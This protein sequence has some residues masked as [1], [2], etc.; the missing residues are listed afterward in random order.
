MEVKTVFK[1][2]I[3][4]ILLLGIVTFLTE[5]YNASVNG[6]LL[7]QK[8]DSAAETS[9]NYF[10]QESFRQEGSTSTVNLP[11]FVSPEDPLVVYASGSFYDC[12][13]KPVVQV[14][15]MFN[16]YP[17]GSEAITAAAG[18][19]ADASAALPLW[20]IAEL[21]AGSNNTYHYSVI[22]NGQQVG[23]DICVKKLPRIGTALSPYNLVVPATDK[24]FG[25]I[26]SGEPAKHFGVVSRYSEDINELR[27]WGTDTTY[28][29]YSTLN[30]FLDQYGARTG[31]VND[32]YM[33][34]AY[35]LDV[36]YKL[37]SMNAF[38]H[39]S[40]AVENGYSP[41]NVGFPMFSWQLNR[42][43]KWHL[44]AAFSGVGLDSAGAAGS[45]TTPAIS[46][47]ESGAACIRWNGFDIY[48]SEARITQINYYAYNLYDSSDLN[49]F[50]QRSGMTV[51]DVN[52]LKK[53][54]ADGYSGNAFPN[55]V[56]AADGT[57]MSF[58]MVV[59]IEYTVPVAYRGITPFR[60]VINWI[61]EDRKAGYAGFTSNNV[62][63]TASGAA[64]YT[65]TTTDMNA[66]VG[67]DAFMVDSALTYVVMP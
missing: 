55:T 49:A 59:D 57:P 31:G 19:G 22:K 56:V 9:L 62:N 8:L 32:Q 58:A 1:V 43:F 25:S 65:Y 45:Y 7:R 39:V 35:E 47:S 48:A 28:G 63:P 10:T 38:S 11:D 33:Q 60:R 16:W 3:G 34:E 46:T 26:Y 21:N 17:G 51:S 61:Q 50:C 66:A 6:A 42:M 30:S 24:Q 64:D 15:E 29:S 53:Y 18:G 13:D 12:P 37:G 20:E 44:C 67:D 41:S 36:L 4:T 52:N 2:I 23:F 14:S 54:N 27:R 5:M 40:T